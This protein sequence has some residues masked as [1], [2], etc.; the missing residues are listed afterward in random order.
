MR[1]GI[2][3]DDRGLNHSVS[4]GDCGACLDSM[5]TYLQEAR[6]VTGWDGSLESFDPSSFRDMRRSLSTL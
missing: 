5:A 6:V 2:Y 1:G 4:G 3:G